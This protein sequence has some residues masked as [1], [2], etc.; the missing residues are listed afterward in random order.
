VGGT[1]P[2]GEGKGVGTGGRR[3]EVGQEYRRVRMVQILCTHACK[4]K[5]ETC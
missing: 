2:A 1:D 5:N 4:W 3:E